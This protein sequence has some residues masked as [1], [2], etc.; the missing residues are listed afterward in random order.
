MSF[1]RAFTIP[2]SRRSARNSIRSAVSR[3]RGRRP[4]CRRGY[5]A[6]S[7]WIYEGECEH[8]PLREPF[9]AS[10]QSHA[11]N[12]QRGIGGERD[13]ER[14]RI[15]PAAP[16]ELHP[17]EASRLSTVICAHNRRL[18]STRCAF[19]VRLSVADRVEGVLTKM[20]SSYA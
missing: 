19:A 5:R 15:V 17:G 1:P 10:E 11:Q 18:T 3:L 20:V 14:G 2:A 7:L 16:H 4:D 8:L 9:L 6:K 12:R 13:C